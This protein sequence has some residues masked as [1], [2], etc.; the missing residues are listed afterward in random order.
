MV[1]FDTAAHTH[2]KH[3]AFQLGLASI[4]APRHEYTSKGG[5]DMVHGGPG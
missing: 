1:T 5:A 3:F 4:R 2:S